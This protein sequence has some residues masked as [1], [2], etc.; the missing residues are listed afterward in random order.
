[1]ITLI[2]VRNAAAPG[3]LQLTNWVA[4]DAQNGRTTVRLTNQRYGMAISDSA[5]S[6]KDP[7][8]SAGRR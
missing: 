2:F 3:G 8:R 4:L 1:M 6:F 7:R 5:F